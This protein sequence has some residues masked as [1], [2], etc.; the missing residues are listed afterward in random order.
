[1]P[2]SRLRRHISLSKA[3]E[4]LIL[5]VFMAA[6]SEAGKKLEKNKTEGRCSLFPLATAVPVLGLIKKASLNDC[7]WISFLR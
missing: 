3:H 4:N 5:V 1:M 7:F 2:K 6:L